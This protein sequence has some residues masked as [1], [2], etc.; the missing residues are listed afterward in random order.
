M[1]QLDFFWSRKTLGRTKTRKSFTL[2]SSRLS[3]YTSLLLLSSH[4]HTYIHIHI[5]IQTTTTYACLF[6]A[7]SSDSIFDCK[8]E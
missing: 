8:L 1:S 2:I 6:I 5:H 3:L 7:S 4:T